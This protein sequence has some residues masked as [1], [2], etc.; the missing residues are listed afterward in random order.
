ML[1]I[2]QCN[3]YN[4]DH[5]KR[6]YVKKINI[7]L[8]GKI[9][10]NLSKYNVIRNK[11]S[12]IYYNEKQKYICYLNGVEI[13]INHRSITISVKNAVENIDPKVLYR[14][15]V[16]HGLLSLLRLNNNFILHGAVIEKEGEAIAILASSGV[17]KTTIS[18]KL[19]K[20]SDIN[21]VSDDKVVISLK[22]LN[23]L[24]GTNSIRIWNDSL[25]RV[26][27]NIDKKYIHPA[28]VNNDKKILDL[29]SF[30]KMS[31]IKNLKISKIFFLKSDFHQEMFNC[32]SI[33]NKEELF[34]KMIKHIDEKE[35]LTV[36]EINDG[37]TG[38]KKIIDSGI[39]GYEIKFNHNFE[40]ID[41][42]VK[43]IYDIL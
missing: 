19:L 32:T 26:F 6:P 31:E 34:V 23:V 14:L 28:N 39:K 37:I 12:N 30:K 25:K 7:N 42:L 22:N 43:K 20:Y 33:T 36:K 10:A 35:F 24:C 16:G 2:N 13:K 40:N 11:I 18:T 9:K 8:V 3:F 4:F 41:S 1:I 21:F 5:L 15:S 38:I 17:G 29:S 27:P